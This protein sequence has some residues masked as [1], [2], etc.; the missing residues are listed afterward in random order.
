M[1]EAIQ[2]DEISEDDMI[3]ALSDMDDTSVSSNQSVAPA[4]QS[5]QVAVD[6][7]KNNT[8]KV[9]LDST[10]A[11]NAAKVDLGSMSADNIVE[12]FKQLIDGKTLEISIKVKN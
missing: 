2:L 1:I 9:D 6:N 3:E 11:D 12:L 5:P 4:A 7:T 10:S 8:A